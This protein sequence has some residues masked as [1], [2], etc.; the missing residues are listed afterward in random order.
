[1]QILPCEF[2]RADSIAQIPLCVRIPLCVF[3]YVGSI[4]QNAWFRLH[5]RPVSTELHQLG[6]VDWTA[7]TGLHR[8]DCIDGIDWGFIIWNGNILLGVH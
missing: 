8:L 1:M 6:C 5:L 7:L 3:H 2:H 4:L